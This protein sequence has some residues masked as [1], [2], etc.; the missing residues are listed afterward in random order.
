MAILTYHHIGEVPPERADHR[1]LFVTEPAFRAQ[2]AWLQQRGYQSVKLDDIASHIAGEHRLPRR[3]IA[4]TF[5]D[6][7]RN[8]LTAGFPALQ[9]YGFSA[10][11][12]LITDR[13]VDREP[14]GRWDDY[15]TRDDIAALSAGGIQFG[16][17]TH[18]HPRLTKLDNDAVLKELETSRDVMRGELGLAADWFCYPYGNFSP[19]I[20]D[21][22]QKAG[23]CGALSTIRDNRPRAGQLFWLPRV[24]VMNDTTPERLGYM[25]STTYHLVHSWKN[26]RRWKSIR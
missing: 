5:D 12:F 19:R 8:N 21:L 13:I 20:A 17:H 7:F 16:S 2:L 18:T 10:T 26:R 22:V 23:Y 1:G 3:W 15:L 4:I 25:L 11:I 9:E 6:G 24:M 14:A